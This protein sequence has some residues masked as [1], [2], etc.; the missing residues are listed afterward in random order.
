MTGT[1][2]PDSDTVAPDAALVH[3]SGR[4]RGT[5]EFIP[6]DRIVLSPASDREIELSTNMR[7]RH[8]HSPFSNAAVTPSG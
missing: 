8:S 7:R 5:T 3:L 2:N 4:R 6:G 1:H